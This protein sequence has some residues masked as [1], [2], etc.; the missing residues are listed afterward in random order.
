VSF[1]VNVNGLLIFDTDFTDGTTVT[2]GQPCANT[3]LCR[4]KTTAAATNNM[5]AFIT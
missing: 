4:N 3:L 5:I 1:A 2:N